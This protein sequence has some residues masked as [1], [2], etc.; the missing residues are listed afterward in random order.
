MKI[1]NANPLRP[2]LHSR[3]NEIVFWISIVQFLIS[4]P[5]LGV[6]DTVLPYILDQLDVSDDKKAKELTGM[7]ILLCGVGMVGSSVSQRP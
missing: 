6:L 1:R 3:D 4:L 2:L 5:E 7:F